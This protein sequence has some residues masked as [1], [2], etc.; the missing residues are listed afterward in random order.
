M[1]A[2][3]CEYI[4]AGRV[5]L[6]CDERCSVIV[7]KGCYFYRVNRHAFI[8]IP[9]HLFWYLYQQKRS[10]DKHMHLYMQI[11][12]NDVRMHICNCYEYIYSAI[13]FVECAFV[14]FQSYTVHVTTF[15][16]LDG[17][18]LEMDGDDDHFTLRYGHQDNRSI[19]ATNA[20]YETHHP[21]EIPG[22]IIKMATVVLFVNMIILSHITATSRI[23]VGRIKLQTSIYMA[24]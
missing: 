9:R 2:V 12:R 1:V 22:M 19:L 20:T 10:S 21:G 17:K 7:A 8:K 6:Y 11:I 3:N 18:S 23:E 14:Q 15:T 13:K 4:V 5:K 24:S 16:R